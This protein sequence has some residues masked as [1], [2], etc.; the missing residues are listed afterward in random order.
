MGLWGLNTVL[1]FS[2]SPGS[3]A[4]SAQ[5]GLDIVAEIQVLA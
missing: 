3:L 4:S 5:L 1:G 2:R